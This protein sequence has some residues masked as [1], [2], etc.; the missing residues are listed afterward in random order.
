MILS[1]KLAEQGYYSCVIEEVYS[2]EPKDRRILSAE[3]D[4]KAK[5]IFPEFGMYAPS[6]PIGMALQN[7][8]GYTYTGKVAHDD[9]PDSLALFAKRF[10]MNGG[11]RLAEISIFSR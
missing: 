2:T 3:G 11:I 8:Y 5:M 7:V 6:H 1:E 10:L 4:I 9:A